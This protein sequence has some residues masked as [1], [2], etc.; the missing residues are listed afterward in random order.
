M[1]AFALNQVTVSDAPFGAFVDMATRLGCVGI[2]ARNDLG[3]PLFDGLDLD[4][5]DARIRDNGLRLLGLSQVYPFN[6]WSERIADQI[7]TLIGS[8]EAAGAETISLIPRNDGSFTGADE[9]R[10][11]LRRAMDNILPI[12]EDADMVAL[13][14]PLGFACASL[15]LKSELVEVID[16]M[17]AQGRIKLVHDT[18]H[19]RLA[20]GG[21]I[22]PDHTGIVHASGVV[23][24]AVVEDQME[25]EHRVLVDTRDRL[26]SVRQIAALTQ[27]GF[28]G[29]ISFECFAPEIRALADPEAAIGRS[30]DFISSQL[31]A[32]AA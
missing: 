10:A 16:A 4:E 30:M 17:E 1:V 20:G 5:A 13:V 26:G 19:H 15:R 25:D 18:F 32:E 2:E 27:A 3:R 31:R 7:R 12:L 24:L 23:D 11:N 6:T 29:A 9:R 22:F 8:A 28:A 21:A 14:E